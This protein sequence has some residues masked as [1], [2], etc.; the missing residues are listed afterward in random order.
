MSFIPTQVR[1]DRLKNK[2]AAEF[3]D[4]KL[5]LEILAEEAAEIIQAKSKIIRFGFDDVFNETTRPDQTNIEKLETEIGHLFAVVD[6]LIARGLVR[7][8]VIE[9]LKLPKWEKMKKW[10]QYKGTDNHI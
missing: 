9:N 2:L 4:D 8:E 10:N 3:P 7:K 6:I 5:T 1:K